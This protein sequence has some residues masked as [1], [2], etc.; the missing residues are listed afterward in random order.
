M[1]SY[2]SATTS[3]AATKRYPDNFAAEGHENRIL[4]TLPVE[5]TRE[6]ILVL[7]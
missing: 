6:Y 3:H 2:T 4:Q 5:P 7:S 1:S